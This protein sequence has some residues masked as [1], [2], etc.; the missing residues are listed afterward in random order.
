L[1]ASRLVA[2]LDV[3][4]IEARDWEIAWS[5]RAGFEIARAP[6]AG[7]PPTIVSLLG[8]YYNGPAPY[9]QFFPDDIRYVGFGLFFSL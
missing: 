5:A 3:K 2:A 6:G 4:V 1:G 9:G 8:E 7:H